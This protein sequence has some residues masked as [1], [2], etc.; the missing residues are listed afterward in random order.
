LIE[1]IVTICIFWF[2]AFLKMYCYGVKGYF[3]TMFPWNLLDFVVCVLSTAA[4]VLEFFV[5]DVGGTAGVVTLLRLL[6]L[7]RFLRVINKVRAITTKK[8]GFDVGI[9]AAR[10]IEIVQK[11]KKHW[12][13]IPKDVLRHLEESELVTKEDLDYVITQIRDKTLYKLVFDKSDMGDEEMQA[14]LSATVDVVV[15]EKADKKQQEV[16]KK[17][18]DKKSGVTAASAETRWTYSHLLDGVSVNVDALEEFM[19]TTNQ[20]DFDV[21]KCHDLSGGNELALLGFHCFM[22]FDLCNKMGISQEMLRNFLMRIQKGYKPNPY[23]NKTH[24]ADVLQGTFF[25]ITACGLEENFT[26]L[27]IF[28]LLLSAIVHDYEHPGVN[29]GFLVN[30]D[31]VLALRYNDKAV[32]EMHHIAAAFLLMKEDPE[33]NLLHKMDKEQYKLLR[34][35]MIDMVLGTEMAAHFEVVA[36]FKSKLVDQGLD[37]SK[38]DDKKL[39]MKMLLHVADVSN[40]ARNV[41]IAGKWTDNVMAEFYMQGDME[42]ERSLKISPFMDRH[43]TSVPKCQLG[44]IDYI[45][46]PLHQVWLEFMSLDNVG[47]EHSGEI[48]Q[49]LVGN[50]STNR[51]YW[52][53]KQ[54]Q[55]AAS[56]KPEA[57]PASPSLSPTPAPVP[58]TPAETPAASEK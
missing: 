6:R 5:Q 33:L 53:E 23:H 40:P 1:G 36:L 7:L 50:I 17:E 8:R 46:Q 27:E 3:T 32:L 15:E 2:E 41:E 25:M 26:D 29:N 11:V 22:H 12:G 16:A 37:M 47:N 10:C 28:S 54:L 57:K 19:T 13:K 24:A 14:Y 38:P 31:D 56:P 20:W 39:V 51:A 48:G 45:V 49:T 58:R 43:T 18:A 55:E 30:T 44:F 21:F 34:S 52:N 35:M 4:L 42:R 9:P